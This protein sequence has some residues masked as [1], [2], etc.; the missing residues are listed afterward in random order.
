ME[1]DRV[2][3]FEDALRVEATSQHF[4]V[5][6]GGGEVGWRVTGDGVFVFVAELLGEHL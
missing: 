6:G 3:E 5:D 2:A 1:V 4:W